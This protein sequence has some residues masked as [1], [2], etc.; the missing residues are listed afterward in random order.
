MVRGPLRNPLNGSVKCFPFKLFK[1]KIIAQN[2]L[3][4]TVVPQMVIRVGSEIS[5]KS[6]GKVKSSLLINHGYTLFLKAVSI[7][8]DADNH[9]RLML[10]R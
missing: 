8:E 4:W 1:K 10:Y 7:P 3:Q 5:I 2:N 9:Y 6:K